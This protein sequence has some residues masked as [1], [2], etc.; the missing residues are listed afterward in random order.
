M[1]AHKCILCGRQ[2]QEVR[3]LYNIADKL[4]ELIMIII[5]RHRDAAVMCGEQAACRAEMRLS[6][7]AEENINIRFISFRPDVDQTQKFPTGPLWRG[8]TVYKE[9]KGIS[10]VRTT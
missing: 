3:V 9:L 4:L 10:R 8:R 5:I 1:H 7:G 2:V 6:S